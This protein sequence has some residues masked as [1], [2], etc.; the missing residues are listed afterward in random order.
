MNSD[1]SSS[2]NTPDS[3]S[4]NLKQ[5]PFA[6]VSRTLVA[7]GSAVLVLLSA[8]AS[9]AARTEAAVGSHVAIYYSMATSEQYLSGSDD[10]AR[11]KGA[12]PFGD[13]KDAVAPSVTHPGK[14]PFPGDQSIFKFALY[15]NARFGRSIGSAEFECEYTTKQNALCDAVYQLPTGTLFASGF[16][17]FSAANFSLAVTGGSGTYLGASGTLTAT[18]GPRHSQRLVI[19]V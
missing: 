14:P 11:G 8:G 7:V 2:L 17:N 12:N 4:S 13:F 16:F 6:S 10:R 1:S 3:H 15:A 18:P 5:P 19:S 9:Q